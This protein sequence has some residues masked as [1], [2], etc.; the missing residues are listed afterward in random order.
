MKI[1][2]QTITVLL[3]TMIFTSIC[4]AAQMGDKKSYNFTGLMVETTPCVINGDQPIMVIFGNVG[5]S[6]IDKGRYVQDLHY[7]L[8]CG[9][10]TS[11]DKVWMFIKANP[12]NWDAKAIATNVTGLGV[13]ILNEGSP[14]ELNTNITIS[15]PANPPALQVL[16]VKNP[17]V[18]LIDQP[19]TSTGTLIVEYV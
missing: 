18:T 13:Q 4:P 1:L 15:D 14:L 5:I 11:K 6:K 3:M 16:L 7:S 8:N 2:R 12:T 19:F 17:K 9:G 10:A